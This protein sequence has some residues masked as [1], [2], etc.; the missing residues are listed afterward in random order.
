LTFFGSLGMDIDTIGNLEGTLT[1]EW[2]FEGVMCIFPKK[3]K[4]KKKG[5][6]LVFFVYNNGTTPRHIG[7]RPN[8]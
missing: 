2:K 4:K 7:V 3:K 5:V 6:I 1:I 8:V